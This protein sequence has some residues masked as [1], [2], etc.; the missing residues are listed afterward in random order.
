VNLDERAVIFGHGKRAIDVIDVTL[1]IAL[2]AEKSHKKSL[3]RAFDH[4]PD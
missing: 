1:R 3:Q 2:L 4:V